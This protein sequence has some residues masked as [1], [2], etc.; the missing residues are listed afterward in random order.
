MN[1]VNNHSLVTFLFYKELIKERMI[2]MYGSNVEIKKSFQFTIDNADI[3]WK[4]K[5]WCSRSGHHDA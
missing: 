3:D 5:R 1:K 2:R 4:F